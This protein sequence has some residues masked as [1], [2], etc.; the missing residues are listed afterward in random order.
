MKKIN[1]AE[2][3][4][5]FDDHWRQ[6]VIAKS[7]GQLIKLAKGIGELT[8]HKHDDEDEMF[9]IH[10]GRLVIQLRDGNV[11]LNPGDMFVVPRGIEHCPV[12][13]EE[14]AFM[15]IGPSVTSAQSDWI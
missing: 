5:L 7:N 1:I 12:A 3:L 10:S 13:E 9:I 11:E 8:W 15:I 2:K 4:S 14:V 6:K